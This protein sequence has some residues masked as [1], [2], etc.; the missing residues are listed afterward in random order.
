MI[1][2][3]RMCLFVGNLP[4]R[5]RWQDVKDLFRR[6]G[7]VLRADVSLGSDNRSRGHGTVLMGSREDGL[8]A[9]EMFN[10]YNWQ[11]RVLE[12]RPD[13]LP[14]EFEFHAAPPPP[15]GALPPPPAFGQVGHGMQQVYS[16]QQQ[17]NQGAERISPSAVL[18][19]GSGNLAG[20][21]LFLPYH[22]QWQDLKDLFRT[23]GNIIRADVV[24]G[25]DGRSKGV[26]HV[27]FATE[28]DALR[29]ITMFDG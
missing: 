12:V 11:T 16:Q 24:L 15:L 29:G 22:I 28:E 19:L 1:Q 4:F 5:V 26:G 9:V 8:R 18:R 13:R 10:G 23:S 25:P 6:A 7:T 17:Q 14:P 3:T 27:L 2:D 20:R 21:V